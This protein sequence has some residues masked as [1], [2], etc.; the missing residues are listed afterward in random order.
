MFVKSKENHAGW[1]SLEGSSRDDLKSRMINCPEET[2]RARCGYMS[3]TV[4][5][6][7]KKE[8]PEFFLA[9]TP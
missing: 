1:S 8:F 9:K 2:I 3:Y 6:W 4:L 5:N 7:L